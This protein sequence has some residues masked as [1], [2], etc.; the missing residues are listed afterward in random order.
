MNDHAT[1][2]PTSATYM[3]PVARS[4]ESPYGFQNPY[5]YVVETLAVDERVVVGD[6]VPSGPV[7]VDPQDAAEDRR[8][9]KVEERLVE[10]FAVGAGAESPRDAAKANGTAG[11]RRS[12]SKRPKGR[13]KDGSS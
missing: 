4:K 13:V 6:R 5:A 9:R 3:S 10:E 12:S 2:T 8:A 1:R 11:R 7:D